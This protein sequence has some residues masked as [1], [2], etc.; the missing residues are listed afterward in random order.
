MKPQIIKGNYWTLQFYYPVG[1][2]KLYGQIYNNITDEVMEESIITN[3]VDYYMMA[4]F[5]RVADNHKSKT[6]NITPLLLQPF[7]QIHE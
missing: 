1:K 6:N 3:L 2:K 5:L 4:D 7:I